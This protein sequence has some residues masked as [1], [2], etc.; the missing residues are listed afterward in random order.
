MN[1]TLIKNCYGF[2]STFVNLMHVTKFQLG[3]KIQSLLVS[4]LKG[5]ETYERSTKMEQCEV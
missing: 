5:E 3:A 4:M 1:L 2:N